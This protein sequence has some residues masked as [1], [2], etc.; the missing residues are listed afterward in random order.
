DFC[1]SLDSSNAGRIPENNAQSGRFTLPIGV[2]TMWRQTAGYAAE[3]LWK[4]VCKH[5]STAPV[6]HDCYLKLFYLQGRE[7][8]PRDWNQARHNAVGEN[9]I[10]TACE[11]GF[12][13]QVHDV[14]VS[15]SNLFNCCGSCHG[16]ARVCSFRCDLEHFRTRPAGALT[17]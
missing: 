4:N 7:L 6:T 2:M 15:C 13:G 16:G 17:G 10:M 9:S 5:N 11:S 3:A 12:G 14:E 1:R 8:A